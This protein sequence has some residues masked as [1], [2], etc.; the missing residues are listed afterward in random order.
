M[1]FGT[2]DPGSAAC[3]LTVAEEGFSIA[4]DS[5][6]FAARVIITNAAPAR[7]P[8]LTWI[9]MSSPSTF[10]TSASV[11]LST[12]QILPCFFKVIGPLSRRINIAVGS[13]YAPV[14]NEIRSPTFGPMFG[15]FL[16]SNSSS[17]RSTFCLTSPS[18]LQ[19]P[20]P[21]QA[22]VIDRKI[23]NRITFSKRCV[24]RFIFLPYRLWMQNSHFF[25]VT[26]W[27]SAREPRLPTT[28]FTS[29]VRGLYSVGGPLTGFV[30]RISRLPPS[31][32][33]T[34]TRRLIA[35]PFSTV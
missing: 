21:R 33:P 16:K 4:R 7:S 2:G 14:R 1:G 3:L 15:K 25:S 20:P 29:P 18:P 17:T 34:C 27:P 9:S 10:S 24:Y 30:P 35:L 23:P 28:I 8:L 32:L 12:S 19:P 26:G 31:V 22:R 13:A 6:S 5:I 11:P